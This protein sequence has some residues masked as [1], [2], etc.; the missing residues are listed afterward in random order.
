MRK[1]VASLNNTSQSLTK[2]AQKIDDTIQHL[3][4]QQAEQGA[5]AIGLGALKAG[6]VVGVLQ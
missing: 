1:A 2:L 4:E 3:Q 5:L 6:L